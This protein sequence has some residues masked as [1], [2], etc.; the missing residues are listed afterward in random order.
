[1]VPGSVQL[2]MRVDTEQAIELEMQVQRAFT[3]RSHALCYLLWTF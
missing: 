3:A 1:M 2:W